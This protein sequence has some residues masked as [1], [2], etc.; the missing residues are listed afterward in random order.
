MGAGQ[1]PEGVGPSLL[2]CPAA[3]SNVTAP[4]AIKK[5]SP[6]TL[7]ATDRLER[8]ASLSLATLKSPTETLSTSTV[9]LVVITPATPIVF[10]VPTTGSVPKAGIDR[11][12]IV[13]PL[14]V[15]NWHRSPT[16]PMEQSTK[17][18]PSAVRVIGAL[19]ATCAASMENAHDA[20]SIAEML[21]RL[22]ILV[23]I[24]DACFPCSARSLA[25]TEAGANVRFPPSSCRQ[26]PGSRPAPGRAE[27]V[28]QPPMANPG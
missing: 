13:A 27:R 18:L 2:S 22:P 4:W 26:K 14:A 28:S 24:P 11:N 23:V 5:G 10:L 17:N 7:C 25:A 9:L 20:V 21:S 1:R 12:W 19:C 15:S 16:T 6:R 3:K 8:L